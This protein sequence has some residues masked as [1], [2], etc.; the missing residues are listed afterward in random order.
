MTFAVIE[1]GIFGAKIVG[2]GITR[3][4]PPAH[5]LDA[6]L[7]SLGSGVCRSSGSTVRGILGSG[8][9]G[10]SRSKVRASF[11]VLFVK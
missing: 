11:N 8:G 4:K 7:T 2:Y 5:L 1:G 6:G 3:R 10:K 9:C